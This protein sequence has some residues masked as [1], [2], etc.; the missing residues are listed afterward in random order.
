MSE[1]E[2]T[3]PGPSGTGVVE[4]QEDLHS[5]RTLLSASLI[6]MIVFSTVVDFFLLKQVSSLRAQTAL[7]E[8]ASN[9]FNTPK[10]IDYWNHLAAYAR[11]HP[12]FAPIINQFGPVL[13][14]TLL[15]NPQAK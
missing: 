14:Q 12:D 3:S 7:F 4:L 5:L 2:Q 15:G 11:T 9:S 13:N 8:A 10:A 6:L 1:F